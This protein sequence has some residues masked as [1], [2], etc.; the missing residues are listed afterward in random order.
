MMPQSLTSGSRFSP[1]HADCFQSFLL[2]KPRGDLAVLVLLEFF[3]AFIAVE[4]ALLTEVFSP[5]FLALC[6]SSTFPHPLPLFFSVKTAD[7]FPLSVTGIH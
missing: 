2:L 7:A 6:T 1:S 3:S 4:H 5:S